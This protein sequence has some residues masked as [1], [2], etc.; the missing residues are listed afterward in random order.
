MVTRRWEAV[1]PIRVRGLNAREH[2][3]TRHR[4]VSQERRTTAMALRA[5]G[6]EPIPEGPV[7]V[8]LT[9]V[10]RRTMDVDNVIGGLKAVRDEIAAALGRD[11]A[12]GSGIQ[13]SYAQ[14]GGPYSV[15][16]EILTGD[17]HG[18]PD[19]L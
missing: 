8:R 17:P 6:V 15:R 3:A 14:A 13:W 16:V 19:H 5:V 7:W 4:R 1:L 12:P 18:L 2:W 9:R 11:D 10:G